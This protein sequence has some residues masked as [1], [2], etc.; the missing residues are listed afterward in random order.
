MSVTNF[1]QCIRLLW[2]HFTEI[3]KCQPDGG[4]R[5]KVSRS[6]KSVGFI[7]SGTRMSAQKFRRIHRTVVEIFQFGPTL[8]STEP[9][10]IKTDV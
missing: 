10:C 1:M 8:P 7:L 9:R 5:G 6:L 4:A 2:R 3:Y